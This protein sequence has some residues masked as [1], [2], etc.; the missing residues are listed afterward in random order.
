MKRI[1][2]TGIT[3]LLGTN[4]ANRLQAEEYEITAIVRDTKRYFGEKS[5]TLQLVE[6]DLFDDYDSY[7][8]DIDIVIHI[9]AVTATN[10]LHYSDYDRVNYQATARLFEKAKEYN[11]SAF[12]YISSANT[13]GYGDF[14]NPGTEDNPM[15]EPFTKHFYAQSKLKAEQ[16]LIQS[17]NS[18]D[19]RI[20]N[21]AFMIGPN[22]S[23]P[24][25]GKIIVRALHKSIVFYPPGGKSFVPVK[26]VVEA[27][28]QSFTNGKSNERYLISGENM[29]YLEFYKKLQQITRDFQIFVRIPKFILV[30]LGYFGFLLRKSG[31]KTSLSISNMQ[32]LCI[33]NYYSNQKSIRDLKLSYSNLEDALKDSVTYFE[34]K[35]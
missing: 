18:I 23:K 10:L 4:L 27:V 30:V 14:K 9:A 22:D 25:S 19:L 24:S 6:L 17:N 28:I 20:L 15:R 35:G 13:I 26:D 1:F 21:P 31:I 2:L 16:Y 5:A 29:S 32:S 11:I 12:I 3:G 33:Q 34:N 8:N 7:L